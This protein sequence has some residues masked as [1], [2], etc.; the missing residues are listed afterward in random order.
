MEALAKPKPKVQY[1]LRT[2]P[3]LLEWL[4]EQAIKYDRPIN[5]MINHA[6]KQ[7]KKQ[8]EI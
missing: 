1:N 6:I 2:E 7:F 4:K 3:E 5:Y 8:Q